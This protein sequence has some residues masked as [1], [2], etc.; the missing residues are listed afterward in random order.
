MNWAPVTPTGE[1]LAAGGLAVLGAGGADGAGLEAEIEAAGVQAQAHA[2]LASLAQAI[3]DGAPVPAAVLVGCLHRGLEIAGDCADSGVVDSPV[4]ARGSDFA[5]LPGAVRGGAL[6]ML[7][8]ARAWLADER[9]AGSRLVLATRHAMSV[10]SEEGA[11]D[12]V[13]AALWGLL[14]SGQAEHPGRFVL[15]DID[16]HAA[17]LRALGTALAAEE[18]QLGRAR[19]ARI[20]AATGTRGCAPE[21]CGRRSSAGVSARRHGADSWRH[22]CSGQ[23]AGSP[24]GR[25]ARGAQSAAGQPPRAR[26]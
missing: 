25:G 15:L 14:R 26:G 23:A 17:S 3:E 18:P 1:V 12:L 22:G 24:S 16:E 11:P 19:R 2:D 10:D 20:R 7:A 5:E 6:R 9:F 13:A 4:F 8:L 21:G